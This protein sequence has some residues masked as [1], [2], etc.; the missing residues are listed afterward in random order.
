M[1]VEGTMGLLHAVDMASFFFVS[2]SMVAPSHG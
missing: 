1:A 2:V